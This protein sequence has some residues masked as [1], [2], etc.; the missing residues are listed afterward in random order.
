MARSRL[1]LGMRVD[2][3]SLIDSVSQIDGWVSKGSGQ[4]ICVANVHMC[5]ECLDSP[6]FQSIVN[7]TN[8]VVPYKQPLVWAPKVIGRKLGQPGSRY[9][10]NVLS[11]I[12]SRYI[13]ECQA[14]GTA[15]FP[16][17]LEHIL[18]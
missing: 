8:P 13:N 12:K 10:F 2:V 18:R 1:I 14:F 15:F 11:W 4:Y 17:W 7:A 6:E 16:T 9:R 5:M 3:T